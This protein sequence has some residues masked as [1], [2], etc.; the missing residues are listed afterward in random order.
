M[1]KHLIIMLIALMACFAL[2][3]CGSDEESSEQTAKVTGTSGTVEYSD[4]TLK[5]NGGEYVSADDGD[6]FCLH[7]NYANNAEE[8]YELAS[9]FVV[10]ADQGNGSIDA[11]QA[12]DYDTEAEANA[13]AEIPTG[14][15]ADCDYY[16]PVDASQPVTIQVLNPD[17]MDTVLAEFEYSPE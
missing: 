12:S 11:R 15:S 5:V 10:V 16:F 8:A 2:A 3:G 17:G 13:W 6:Y 7:M 14:E 4:A 9:S 1:K